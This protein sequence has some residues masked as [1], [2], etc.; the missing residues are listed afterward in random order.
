MD[1]RLPRDVR[2]AARVGTRRIDGCEPWLGQV[3][4]RTGAGLFYDDDNRQRSAQ[5]VRWELAHGP[6]PPRSSVSPRC[7]VPGCVR[8][9]HLRLGRGARLSLPG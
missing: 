8:L 6:L 2:F 9:E 4:A 3:S 7:G 1:E 5:V